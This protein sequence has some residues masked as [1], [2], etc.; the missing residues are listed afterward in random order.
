MPAINYYESGRRVVA[1]LGDDPATQIHDIAVP[2]A[3]GR[4]VQAHAAA[5]GLDLVRAALPPPRPAPVPHAAPPPPPPAPAGPA[6]TSRPHPKSL[7]PP[8]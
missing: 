4:V 1:W 5:L 2:A 7:T 6:P 8:S 3:I